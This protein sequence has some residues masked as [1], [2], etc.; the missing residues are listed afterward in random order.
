MNRASLRGRLTSYRNAS[1]LGITAALLLGLIALISMAS[2][3]SHLP[4][5]LLLHSERLRVRAALRLRCRDVA[6]W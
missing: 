5:R 4:H 1:G 6:G 3:A 2:P